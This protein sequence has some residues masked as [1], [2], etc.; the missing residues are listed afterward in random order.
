MKHAMQKPVYVV[1]EQR[2]HRPVFAPTKCGWRFVAIGRD[3]RI[4]VRATIRS[5][6]QDC[7]QLGW[8]LSYMVLTQKTFFS[9][10]GPNEVKCLLFD[11]ANKVK[12]NQFH[13]S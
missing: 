8:F 9:W 4:V 7:I 5:H 3:I 6:L 12:C 1:C 2:I 10:I 13:M 11:L